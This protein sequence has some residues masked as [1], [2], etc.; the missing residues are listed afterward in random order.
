METPADVARRAA[1]RAVAAA[2]RL[3]GALIRVYAALLAAAG[4]AALF[5]PEVAGTAAPVAVQVVGAALLGFAA[6]T[7]NARGLVLGGIYGRAVT[8]GNQ[9]FAFVAALV[10]GRRLLEAPSVA[11]GVLFG[12][13]AFGAVLFTVLMYGSVAD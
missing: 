6:L 13:V 8:V 2:A 11:V 1:G 7:W 10:L 9:T 12:I 5:A 4:V 3:R